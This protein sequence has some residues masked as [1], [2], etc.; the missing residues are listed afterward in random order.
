MVAAA[1]IACSANEPAPAPTGGPGQ[2][3]VTSEL[4]TPTSTLPP[5]VVSAGAVGSLFGSPELTATSV[6][7][8]PP[9]ITPTPYLGIQ[10]PIEAQKAEKL[11]TFGGWKTDFTRR[12]VNLASIDTVLLRDR[13]PPIDQPEFTSTKGAPDYMRDDEPVIALEVGGVARAYPLAVLMWHEIVNDSVGGKAVAVT[14]CPLCNSSVV[15]DRTVGGNTLTF[16]TSGALRHSDLVMWDRQTESW[17]QQITGEAIVGD[18]TGTVLDVLPSTI[19][20]WKS[21][22]DTYPGGQL[23]LRLTNSDGSFRRS[24]DEPPYAGYDDVNEHPFLFSGTVDS[25][26]SAMTRVVA[27]N[28]NGT[29]VAYPFDFLASN[30]VIN[31]TVGGEDVV[32]LYDADVASAFLNSDLGRTVS[33]SA[34]VFKRPSAG[35]FEL[36]DGKIVDSE[37]GSVWTISGIA[38]SGP[39]KGTRLP[40]V[41]HGGVYFWFAWAVF[42]PDTEVRNSL[43]KLRS[44]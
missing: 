10:D 44:N 36:R 32:I 12:S 31:D 14:F 24:Y 39:A 15:F 41:Q 19:T 22:K 1:A 33:G 17:W 28:L 29:S 5:P 13:I 38:K 40:P 34:V 11:A 16:G 7:P 37:T 35:E 21:F 2:S 43:S 8:P 27:V 6:P 30:P 4:A 3:Q 26:L 42:M 23:L 18:L 25:R 9:T 20:S